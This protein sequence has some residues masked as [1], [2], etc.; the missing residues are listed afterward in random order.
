MGSLE[1]VEKGPGAIIDQSPV[2]TSLAD[3][4]KSGR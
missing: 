3:V 2:N 4:E 1:Q